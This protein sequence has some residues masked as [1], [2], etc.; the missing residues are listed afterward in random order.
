MR[1]YNKIKQ[2]GTWGFFLMCMGAL[3]VSS[4][5]EEIDTSDLYTFTGETVSSFLSS[6]TNKDTY[7]YYYELLQNVRQSTHTQSSVANLL[8]ARGN[9]TC[10]A[11]TNDAITAYLDTAVNIETTDFQQF[12]DSVKKEVF[13]YDSIAKVIV[14]NSIIDNGSDEAYETA[15]FPTGTFNLPNMNDRYLTASTTGESGE[16]MT[17]VINGKVKITQRDNKVENGYV[18]QVDGVIAPTDASV[19]DL[20]QGHENMQ[21]FSALLRETGWGDS[22]TK[23]VDEEYE[24]I[25]PS[26][27]TTN[28]PKP[29]TQEVADQFIP[30]H[31]KYGFTVFAET[32][33]TFQSAFASEGITGSNNIENLKAY[34]QKKYQNHATFKNLTWGTTS[35]DLKDP[36]NAINQF[37]SYHLLPISLPSNQIVIHY[38][39][40][41]FDLESA[42]N[43][44]TQ[45][46]I[47]VFEY[48]ETMTGKGATRRLMKVTESKQS[49]GVRI[50][51]Y[52]KCDPKTYEESAALTT[53]GVIE[54]VLINT[55]AGTEANNETAALNGYIYPLNELLVYSD[56]VT[57][58]VLNE[59]IRFDAA[60]IMPELINLGYRRPMGNYSGG[61]KNIYFPKEF[62]LQNL[63]VQDGT[64]VFY[65]AGFKS[66]WG[67]YQGDEFNIAGNYDITVKLPP[68]PKDGTYEIRYGLQATAARGMAQIYFGEK[69]GNKVPQP[70]GIPLD[71]RKNLSAYGWEADSKEDPDYNQEV[72][73]KLRNQDHMKGP[74]YFYDGVR[75]CTAY[76]TQYDGRRIIVRRQMEANKTYYLRFKSVLDNDKTEFYF[77]YL[78][79]CPSFVYNNPT[80]SEDEW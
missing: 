14:Y 17:Y 70:E 68:V 5:R 13:V 30:E 55:T 32:D 29:P 11:P 60:S 66:G 58:K 35:A 75:G 46:T 57:D 8:S 41:D 63:E 64:N 36:M 3:S 23:Y 73:K 62:K 47:P 52:M 26:I 48:Y 9:Y 72:N 38:N 18:H 19:F 10:F 80:E 65:F 50:N 69:E 25:Y 76:E 1:I 67:N 42:L 24:E 34:L 59:R 2:T 20:L 21:I 27:S 45:I 33:E 49:G 61:K 6:E 15:V 54:G 56:D 71:L 39:E 7:S 79:L 12:M 4:C 37:V 40:K 77:D 43:G 31:R 28:M 44:Q 51:R 53:D 78:E 16:K 74:R 22:L